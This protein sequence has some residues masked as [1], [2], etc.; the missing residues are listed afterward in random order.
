MLP[1]NQFFFCVFGDVENRVLDVGNSIG[2][3]FFGVSI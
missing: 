3:R 1:V 2:N